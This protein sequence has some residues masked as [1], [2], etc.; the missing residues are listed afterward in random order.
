MNRRNFLR[1]LPV[2][3][4]AGS[5]ATRAWGAERKPNILYI[6]SDDHTATAIGAYGSRLTALNPTPNIDRIAREGMLFSN[7]FCTNSICV[8]SRATIMTGQYSHTTGVKTLDGE[9]APARQHLA[10][11]MGQAGYQTAMVGKWH[12]GAEP[13]A[14]DYYC[15]FP[16]QGSYFNP[17][18]HE[19]GKPWPDNLRRF[20]GYDSSH[21]SDVVTDVSLDW[22]KKRDT[23]RPFFLMHHFKA[24]HDNF[25]N[26]ERYDWLYDDVEIPEPD[27]LW[28]S[29]NYGSE[30]TKG[31]GTSIGK[32]NTRRN[33]GQHMFVNPKLGDREYLKTAYQRYMKKY[34]RCV[35]GVDDNVGRI[36]GYLEQ[37]GELDNT[38]ILYSSDQ[39]MMLGEHDYI[40][41]RWMY[42]ESMRMPLLARFPRMVRAG[43]R[44]DALVNNT[45]YAP[46]MLELAGV[47][48]PD[49][50]QGRSAVPLMRGAPPPDW[51]TATYYRYWMHMAHH[52]NPAHYGIRTR[53]FKLIFF[54]GL[55]LDAAGALP[56]PTQ[57]GWELYDLREDPHEKKN[58]YAEPAHRET[59]RQ[60]KAE[61]LALKKE[62]GDND[63]EYPALME[64]RRKYW[65]Q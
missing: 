22:L 61:L 42:E 7:T 16:G 57:P 64:V 37:A 17:I 30:A 47:P 53:N 58:V 18:L 11:L 10:W 50:M 60:L 48:K 54:Y 8:P 55:P 33:M 13:A 20:S 4:A 19:K 46:T 44:S 1:Q 40:D 28:A 14:F 41:K 23:S 12:L 9:L 34:L 45:D 6:M 25:E 3:A 32:R 15:V 43:T 63:E 62:V 29:P 51:R 65:D 24:P 2:T 31:M 52:D 26:A 49:F 59:V 56:A 5:A 36:L 38:L 35:K 39:G 21:S 27:T